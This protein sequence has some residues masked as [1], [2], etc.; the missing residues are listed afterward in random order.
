M[1][2]KTTLIL[3]VVFVVL[4]AFVLFLDKKPAGRQAAR[5][6]GEARRPGLGR[7]R[8]DHAQEG[9][10]KRS[11][12]KKDDKGDWM[13]TEPIEAKADA[14]E[15]DRLADAFADLKIERVVEKE[16]G[17]PKKYQIPQ[18]EVSLWTKGQDGAGQD[19]DRH[20]E[21]DRQV[22]LRPEGGRQADR[23]PFEHAD[24]RPWTRSSSTSARRTSSSSRPTDVAGIKVSGQGRRWEAAKKDDELVLTSAAQ[25][26]GQGEQ[27]HDLLD[28]LSNLKAK[29]FAAEDKSRGR[30]EEVRPGQARVRR[31]P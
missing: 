7:R 18:K 24:A 19:P 4:L 29:E 11:T 10:S 13:I 28:A 20:G 15:V 22:P 3:L 21:P 8:E 30:P 23:P 5:T 6:R 17:D 25:G 2:F 9:T 14:L 26:P 27:D 1:K 31:S 16:G 12:F